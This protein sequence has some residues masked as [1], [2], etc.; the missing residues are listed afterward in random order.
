LFKSFGCVAPLAA[1]FRWQILGSVNICADR[2]RYR[3]AVPILQSQRLDP[4]AE[5]RMPAMRISAENYSAVMMRIAQCCQDRKSGVSRGERLV[6][7]KKNSR[8]GGAGCS[9]V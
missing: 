6:A 4:R 5:R 2:G 1:P 9:F 8:R 7:Q 3:R